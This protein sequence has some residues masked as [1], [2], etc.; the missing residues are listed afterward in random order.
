MFGNFYYQGH[1]VQ[2]MKM[3]KHSGDMLVN[4]KVWGTGEIK[5]GVKIEELKDSKEQSLEENEMSNNGGVSHYNDGTNGWKFERKE[6]TFDGQ[7][8]KF[9]GK[10]NEVERETV[11]S[12]GEHT[13]TVTHNKDEIKTSIKVTNG[14]VEVEGDNVKVTGQ[15]TPTTIDYVFT[16]IK[17]SKEF[18]VNDKGLDKFVKDNKLNMDAVKLMIDGKQKTH[19]GFSVRV[20]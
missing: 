4:F 13:S 17:D 1:K 14:A 12:D 19:K 6:D 3:F 5:Q 15:T 16:R 2:I 8:T 18:L 7:T 20:K 9:D 11:I 10:G